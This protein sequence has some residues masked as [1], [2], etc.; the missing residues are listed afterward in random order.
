MDEDWTVC[1]RDNKLI[2]TISDVCAFPTDI[3]QIIESYSHIEC[4]KITELYGGEFSW[5]GIYTH[6]YCGPR[7]SRIWLTE[8]GG[9]YF[10]IM[11]YGELMQYVEF[12]YQEQLLDDQYAHDVYGRDKS[13]FRG[14]TPHNCFDY[15]LLFSTKQD[16]FE[17]LPTK[18]EEETFDFDNNNSSKILL[19]YG[20]GET[21]G[22]I[23]HDFDKVRAEIERYEKLAIE[24][25]IPLRWI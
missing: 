5:K 10:H 20:T 4:Y 1:L 18:P 13:C 3:G 6:G 19:L 17:Y 24:H 12:I 9:K 25:N 23:L 2:Q 15:I 14:D 8:M 21:E 22:F 7:G 16:F 11:E